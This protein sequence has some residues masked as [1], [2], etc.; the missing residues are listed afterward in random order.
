MRA[1]LIYYSTEKP[2]VIN[3]ER[4]VGRGNY[5]ISVGVD[6]KRGL[7]KNHIVVDF[8]GDEPQVVSTVLKRLVEALKARDFII[9][10]LYENGYIRWFVGRV[11]SPGEL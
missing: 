9:S 4:V 11:P 6:V 5:R 8:S 1:Q 2:C 10:I 7:F 3:I